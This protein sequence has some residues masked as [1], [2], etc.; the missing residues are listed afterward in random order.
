MQH[1]NRVLAVAFSPDNNTVATASDDK[2]AQLWDATTG[3]SI[4]KIMR[5]DRTVN[6]VLFSPDGKKLLTGSVDGT[7][8]GRQ[9]G[10]GIRKRACS[11]GQLV[12]VLAKIHSVERVFCKRVFDEAFLARGA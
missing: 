5:H 11:S 6:A 2:L 7:A 4:R 12:L 9:R 8:L 3:Q 10:I 1:R